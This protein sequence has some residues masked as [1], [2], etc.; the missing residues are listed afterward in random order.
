MWCGLEIEL[1]GDQPI[2]RVPIA[3]CKSP[4]AAHGLRY[5]EAVIDFQL[6]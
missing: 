5:V 1:I 3:L 2:V 6:P 4:R